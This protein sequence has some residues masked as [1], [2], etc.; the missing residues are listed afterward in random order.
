MI[1]RGESGGN[2]VQPEITSLGLAGI[3][4]PPKTR[5]GRSSAYRYGQET[6]ERGRFP[7]EWP[8]EVLLRSILRAEAENPKS[9]IVCFWRKVDEGL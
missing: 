3:R 9:R 4:P 6:T 7:T 1:R 2:N 8:M 5:A